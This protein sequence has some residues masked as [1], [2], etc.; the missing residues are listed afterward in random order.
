MGVDDHNL[1]WLSI[2]ARHY[3]SLQENERKKPMK[4]LD[5]S[6]GFFT[7]KLSNTF[8]IYGFVYDSGFMFGIANIMDGGFL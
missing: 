4:N 5:D 8:G 2:A 3:K 7:S 6:K 1:Y